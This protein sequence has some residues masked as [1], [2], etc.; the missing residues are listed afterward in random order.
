MLARYVLPRS[1]R[2]TSIASTASHG[3]EGGPHL[4]MACLREGRTLCVAHG[5]TKQSN[6]LDRRDIDAADLMAEEWRAQR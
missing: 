5:F 3:Q 2:P 4:R 1:H 6:A